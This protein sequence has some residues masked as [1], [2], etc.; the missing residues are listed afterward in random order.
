MILASG[1]FNLCKHVTLLSWSTWR[2]MGGGGAGVSCT[3]TDCI[4]FLIF[5]IFES[6]IV[7]LISSVCST[8]ALIASCSF[9]YLHIQCS[10]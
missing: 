2:S 3:A 1:S 9:K 4:Q 8:S 10:D 6:D 5:A 7:A